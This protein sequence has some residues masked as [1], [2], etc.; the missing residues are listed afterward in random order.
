MKERKRHCKKVPDKEIKVEKKAEVPPSQ[1]SDLNAQ[2]LAL[3]K[4]GKSIL[5]ISKMLHVG[6][7]EVKLIVSLYGGK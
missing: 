5:E 3:Y 7:G 2:M 6:Q 1:D 4:Q